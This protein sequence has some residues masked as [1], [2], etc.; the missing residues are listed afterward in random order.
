MRVTRERFIKVSALA[1]FYCM[2]IIAPVTA[3]QPDTSKVVLLFTGDIHGHLE[4]WTG[5]EGDMDGKRIGGFDRLATAVRAVKE[6][7][8]AGIVLLLDAGDAVGDTIA[9]IQ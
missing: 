1:L 4:G 7:D 3:A 8:G 5:W 6:E 2:S 9:P